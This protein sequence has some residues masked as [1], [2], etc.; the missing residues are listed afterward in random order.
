MR[1]EPSFDER[2]AAIPEVTL[3]DDLPQPSGRRSEP[4]FAED[5]D[6]DEEDWQK[7][8]AVERRVPVAEPAPRP[9]P[10][11][12]ARRVAAPAR[13]ARVPAASGFPPSNFSRRRRA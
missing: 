4:A 12:P 11:A 9:K 1:V 3:D 10:A 6:D 13:R 7:G 2:E 5:D 8:E